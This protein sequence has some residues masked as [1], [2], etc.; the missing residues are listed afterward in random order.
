MG[1]AIRGPARPRFRVWMLILALLP[2][3][4]AWPQG[5]TKAGATSMVLPVSPQDGATLGDW[6]DRAASALSSSDFVL[7]KAVAEGAL[8]VDGG[9]SDLHYIVARASYATNGDVEMALNEVEASLASNSFVR[10]GRDDAIA[11]ES[12]LLIKLRRWNDA[13]SLLE[14]ADNL[15]NADIELYKIRAFLGLGDTKAALGGF[16]SARAFWPQDLRFA[17]L[18]LQFWKEGPTDASRKIAD[19]IV[20]SVTDGS[21]DDPTLTAMAIPFIPDQ[22][23]RKSVLMALRAAKGGVAS[24]EALRYGLIDVKTAIDEI[25]PPTNSLV[26]RSDIEGLASLV[27]PTGMKELSDRLAA[28]SGRVAEDRDSDGATDSITVYKDGQ[29]V[30][31]DLDADQ[32]GVNELVVNFR[33][34]L[35]L[36]AFWKPDGAAFDFTWNRWPMLAS[37]KRHVIATADGE[38]SI[39][40]APGSAATTPIFGT[41]DREWSLADGA[42][43]WAPLTFR[44]FPS[45]DSAFVLVDRGAVAP[46][47]ERALVASATS[48]ILHR[49]DGDLEITL[50]SGLA[51]RGVLSAAGRPKA[52]FSYEKGRPLLEILDQDGDGRFESRLRLDPSSDPSDPLVLSYES[53]VDGDGIYEYKEELVPP[54]RRTWDLGT[55]PERTGGQ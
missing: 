29:A 40:S 7:A 44:N 31:W 26:R 49:S 9:N 8:E 35:P 50:R 16:E 10:Y 17:R 39:P 14:T 18:F 25:L 27:G 48:M 21:F 11:F 32:D 55:I 33:F 36:T 2:V 53:D 52:I 51:L 12:E 38:L 23:D 15:P 46:P 43:S 13:L 5:Q 30:E 45:A 6:I 22:R 20:R 42:L 19:A 3:A 1:A 37:A 54:Y 4:Q 24:L 47:S 28:F 34:G 41:V